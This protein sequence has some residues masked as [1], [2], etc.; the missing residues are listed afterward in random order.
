MAEESLFYPEDGGIMFFQ[1][2]NE[3]LSDYMASDPRKSIQSYFKLQ[4][5][6]CPW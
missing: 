1:N 3:H 6:F 4:I 2:V 5:G